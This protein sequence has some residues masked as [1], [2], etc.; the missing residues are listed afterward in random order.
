MLQYFSIA[1]VLALLTHGYLALRLA[2]AS[3]SARRRLRL[4]LALHG[5]LLPAL[6]VL[7]LRAPAPWAPLAVP[8]AHLAFFDAGLTVL[9]FLSVLARD[10]LLLPVALWRRLRA[11]PEAPASPSRREAL[12]R[13]LA[14]LFPAS[15]VGASVAGYAVAALPPVLE[16]TRAALPE[17]L[18]PRG[19]SLRAV[20]LSD[21][22]VGPTLRGPW[23]AALVARCNA[24]EPDLVLLTGDLVDGFVSQLAAQLEPLRALRARHGVYFV[25]GNHEYYY[26]A[27]EWRAALRSLGVTVLSN[28]HAM[29]SHEG[30]T[31]VLAGVEDPASGARTREA[32]RA[33][34]QQALQGAPAGALR[35]LLSHRPSDAPLAAELGFHV[36]LSGHV[37]AGQFFPFTLWARW[38]ER[39]LAGLY[40][41]GGLALYVNRGAGY[42][43][44]PNRLGAR[45]ELALLELLSA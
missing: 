7:T 10:V 18:L 24:L 11:A 22:H 30:A 1:S 44:P 40:R 14:G 2:P 33:V 9:L 20:H 45:Q 4:A 5:A 34:L 23:L 42:W 21:L 13:L 37:H 32:R 31:L 38:R 27:A 29:L 43:G 36:Q 12:G 15:A 28:E 8:L 39:F 25:T 41:V 19:I 3:P 35:I 6:L 16:R 17:G 26:R